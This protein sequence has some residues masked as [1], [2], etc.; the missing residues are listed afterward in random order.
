[1]GDFGS[2]TRRIWQCHM[3]PIWGVGCKIRWV[4]YGFTIWLPYGCRY[5]THMG[6]IWQCYW[7]SLL[8]NPHI[9][10]PFSNLSTDQRSTNA[11]NINSFTALLCLF[12]VSQLV[13]LL[14]LPR[15]AMNSAD[16]ATENAR[17]E[18]A[19]RS[20][21]QG[22]KMRDLKMRDQNAGSENVGPSSMESYLAIKCANGILMLCQPDISFSALST[23][24][25]N[26]TQAMCLNI[27]Y[28]VWC[29]VNLKRKLGS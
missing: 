3:T 27:M 7:G 15:D 19:G 23:V 21:M 26:R 16:G 18:N 13:T 2:N 10:L 5:G 9:S 1:M 20:I 4:P 29:M 25:T 8:L 28:D 17:T 11:L 22:W 6:V 14:F 12:S 24:I